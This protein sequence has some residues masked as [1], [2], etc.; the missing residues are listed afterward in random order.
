MQFPFTD[1]TQYKT[2]FFFSISCSITSAPLKMIFNDLNVKKHNLLT[3]FAIDLNSA[4]GCFLFFFVI[5]GDLF[6]YL[7]ISP[8]NK[9]TLFLFIFISYIFIDASGWVISDVSFG[10]IG[11]FGSCNIRPPHPNDPVGIDVTPTPIPSA[12]LHIHTRNKKKKKKVNFPC[13]QNFNTV[14]F[15]NK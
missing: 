3:N 5:W 7:M 6:P 13:L 2:F 12:N 8:T 10:I 1:I 14:E 9:Y 15:S 4:I 11:G